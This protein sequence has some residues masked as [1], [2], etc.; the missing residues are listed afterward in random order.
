MAAIV[1]EVLK[2]SIAEDLEISSGDEIISINDEKLED[3]VQYRYLT[4]AEEIDLHIKRK[5]GEEE[6]IEIEKDFEDDLGIVFTSAVF[7]KIMPCLN[8]CIFCFVDQQPKGLRDTLYIKDDD[9]RLSYLQG[10]Y[11]T[12]TNLKDKDY[13]RLEEQRLGPL[14]V[15]V[16]T[17]NPELRVRMMKNKNAGKILEQLKR[18]ES[19]DIP[20]HTQIVLCP[21]YNDGGELKRTL[22]DL[23]NLKNVCSVAVVPVG[24]TKFRKEKLKQVDKE[25]ALETIK[26]ADEMNEK[27]KK[28]II[29]LSD[30]FYLL[31]NIDFPDKKYYG[32]YSQLSD[33]VGTSRLLLDD[34]KK[35]KLPKKIKTPKKVSLFTGESAFPTIKKIVDK[36]NKIENFEMELIGVK[37]KFWGNT[38]TVTG[39]VTGQDL[40]NSLSLRKLKT[41]EIYIPSIMLRDY[42]EDFLD[43]I[44]VSEIEQ[45]NNIKINIIKDCY[46]TKEFEDMVSG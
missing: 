27:L 19:L 8:K 29:T 43:G 23:T 30:E 13:K 22:K 34:F 17:T 26:I 45:R 42:T 18:L 35:R 41:S 36:L 40:E 4:M 20:V 21:D 2:G 10:T 37:S 33:G 32:N 9:Y 31:A 11:V 15:S 6:I 24:I 5:N 14:Y 12:L 44:T 39:L 3:F 16:H 7:D 25:K 28:H 1:K 46:S 38:I